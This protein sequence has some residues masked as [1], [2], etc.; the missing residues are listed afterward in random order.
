MLGLRHWARRPSKTDLWVGSGDNQV[1]RERSVT[2]ARGEGRS[3]LT[4]IKTDALLPLRLTAA[5]ARE[6]RGQPPE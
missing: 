5:V 6:A 2:H 3:S 1:L 4:T